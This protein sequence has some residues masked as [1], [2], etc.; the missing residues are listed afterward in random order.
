MTL[1]GATLT[2]GLPFNDRQRVACGSRET[3]MR[4]VHTGAGGLRYGA[5]PRPGQ[6][7]G[8]KRP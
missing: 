7:I 1:H 4:I 2:Q 5:S 6:R 3:S 8:V